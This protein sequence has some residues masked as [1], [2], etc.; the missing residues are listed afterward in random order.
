MQ[1][2]SKTETRRSLMVSLFVFGLLAALFIVPFQFRS[3]AGGQKDGKGATP[4]IPER[5]ENYDI[6][7]QKDSDIYD[8]LV[9]FRQ[10]SGKSASAVADVRDKFVRGEESLRT[11]VP[12]LKVEY[13]SDI[14]IPEVITPDVW[15]QKVSFL[16]G[17]TTGSKAEVLRN[18]VKQNNDLVGITDPQAASLKVIADY[19]NPD[20][21]LSYV[22]LDQ[23]VGE[24]PIFRGEI[25]AG[26]TKQGEIIRVINNLAPGLDYGSLSSE[27]GDPAAAVRAAA[28][29]INHTLRDMDVAYNKALSNRNKAVYG[30]GNWPTL[31][32]KFY[33]P[34]EP[35]VARAAWRVQLWLDHTAYMLVIDAQTGTVLWRKDLGESQTQSVSYNVYANANS[36]SG[37]LSSPAP[38]VPGLTRPSVRREPLLRGRPSA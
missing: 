36:I 32:E 15:K 2:S 25:K 8:K 24:I 20:G 19:T 33:F 21:N 7:D 23:L 9:S 26:F 35:G 31:A 27:F 12:T 13:N 30:E 22:Q 1:K 16:S 14:R 17:P 38:L 34:T 4:Q 10:E 5:I 37:I 18:F 11:S 29:N 28:G 3:E 6:R